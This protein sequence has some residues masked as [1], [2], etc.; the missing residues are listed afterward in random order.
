MDPASPTAASVSL[1]AAVVLLAV[2]LAASLLGAGLARRTRLGLA[3]PVVAWLGLEAVFFGPGSVALALFEGRFGPALYVAGA[4]AAVAV[5]AG[6]SAWVAL[7]RLRSPADRDGST[8]ALPPA[9]PNTPRSRAAAPL[10]AAEPTAA[11][12]RWPSRPSILVGV[13]IA[14]LALAA[15]GPDLVEHGIPLLVP[16]ITGAR[17]E[18][19]GLA[20][21]PLRVAWPALAVLLLF[22][23][24]TRRAAARLLRLRR[25]LA[26]IVLAAVV[27]G[28]ALLASR[29]LLAELL[30]ALLFAWWIAGRHLPRPALL[31][32]VVGG[33]LV[34]VGLGA[35]RIVGTVPGREAEVTVERTISRLVLVQPRTLAA[36]QEAIPAETDYFG[37]LTWL[38]RLGPLLGRDD[39]PNLGYWIYP[40]VVP[41]PQ[42]VPGY[43]APGL[44][45]E[46]WANFGPWGLL[47]FLPVGVLA[48]RLGALVAVVGRRGRAVDVAA[49]SL[50]VLFLARTHALGLNGLAVLLVL[51]LGWRLLVDRPAELG[52]WIADACRWRT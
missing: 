31:A 28:E 38:R 51:V 49:A 2:L 16:D 32:L 44:I 1:G 15:I 35:I 42:D 29:Y 33:L 21:Q 5:G 45:G 47:L 4:V 46:A 22:V 24:T 12:D 26:V 17:T 34:F 8:L 11:S 40:R 39:I 9:S 23:A 20:V 10:E 27:V 36:L 19:S 14:A 37:G 18:I 3:H 13:T 7:R 50:A 25:L 30:V 52:G 43:A 41:G 48:E 6:L